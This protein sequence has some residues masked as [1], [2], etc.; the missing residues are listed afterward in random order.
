MLQNDRST[1]TSTQWTLLSNIT[2]AYDA[3]STIPYARSVT[4]QLSRLSLNQNYD[5]SVALDIIRRSVTSIRSF[6]HSIPDFQILTT[7]E[8]RS[9]LDRNWYSIG[10]FNFLFVLRD[11]ALADSPQFTSDG[12]ISYSKDVIERGYRIKDQLEM[13]STLIKMMVVVLAFSSNCLV[14]DVPKSLQDDQLTLG[15]FRLLGSQNVFVELLWKYM[16]YRYGYQ[17]TVLRFAHLVKQMLNTINYVTQT[18]MD[19][20]NHQYFMDKIFAEDRFIFAASRN[21]RIPLWGNVQP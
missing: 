18:Y 21:V 4:E 13:D 17:E 2:H 20:K 16:L 10:G 12:L 3:F 9:L 8:Q 6:I 11:S 14:M 15:T 19:N 5:G 7:G 1:L